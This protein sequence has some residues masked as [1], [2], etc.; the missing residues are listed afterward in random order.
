MQEMWNCGMI[1]E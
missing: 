1:C